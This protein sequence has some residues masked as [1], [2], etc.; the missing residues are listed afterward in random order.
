LLVKPHST[1]LDVIYGY[2]LKEVFFPLPPL[3]EQDHITRYLD[4][5]TTQLDELK[6]QYQ[7]QITLL[8]E[9]KTALISA[10]VTGKVDVRGE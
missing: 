8:E 9:Y 6:A 2:T 7:Q 4:E 1:V 3:S 10:V 5:K